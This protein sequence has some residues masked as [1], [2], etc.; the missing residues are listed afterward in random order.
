MTRTQ[1]T[2]LTVGDPGRMTGGYLFHRRL[3]ERAPVNGADI[4]FVSIPDLALPWA[5]AAGPAWLRTPAM[6]TADVVVLDS[7]AA[8]AAAP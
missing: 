5:V 2:F 8:T 7:L 3:A 6:R 1:V 4:T